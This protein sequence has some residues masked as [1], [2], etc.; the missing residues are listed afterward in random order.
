METLTAHDTAKP[1][2]MNEVLVID[3]CS[4][5]AI[6]WHER[7]EQSGVHALQTAVTWPRDDAGQA[8]RRIR[9]HHALIEEEPRFELVRTVT[10]LERYKADGKVGII[11]GAQNTDMLGRDTA[12]VEVFRDA[13]IR[14]MQLNYNER[15]AA[16]D[17]CLESTDAGLSFFGRE[18]IV[19]MNE[20]GV[21]VDLADAGI[22]SSLDAIEVSAKPCVFSHVN[23][24]ATALEQ[25][26]NVTDE[27]IRAV[28]A[29]GGL[30]GVVPHSPLSAVTMGEWPTLDDF[31]RHIDYVVDLVGID[32]IS[33]GSDSEATPGG[34]SI[35]LSFQM[36][37]VGRT[38]RGADRSIG[39]ISAAMGMSRKRTKPLT[40][41]EMAQALQHGN[42]GPTDLE[43]V[44]KLPNLVRRLQELGWSDADLGKLLGGNLVRVYAEVWSD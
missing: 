22:R 38:G 15:N 33:F 23:P 21:L 20:A 17:G 14:M 35:E 37:E 31:I 3:G 32:H 1:A 2:V 19:A 43:S 8:L 24:R 26:R 28:A 16:S 10:D 25:Q 27:Q 4:V 39:S 29:K 30:I 42:W 34:V 6:G 18:L 40:Y 11:L 13:G 7:I 9:A 12:L 36:G 5:S 41:F 44:G